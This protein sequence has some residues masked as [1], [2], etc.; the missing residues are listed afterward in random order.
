MHEID[1]HGRDQRPRAESERGE[2]CFKVRTWSLFLYIE[3][4]PRWSDNSVY[5][6]TRRDD[7][8]WMGHAST[9]RKIAHTHARYTH[10]V[11]Q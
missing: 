4:S 6:Y 1:E 3:P 5:I 10:T 11:T 2:Y 8:R 9:T 7:T